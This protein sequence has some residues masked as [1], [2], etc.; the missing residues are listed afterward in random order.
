MTIFIAII[1]AAALAAPGMVVAA[2]SILRY[3]EISSH[4][5]RIAPEY[6]LIGS[7]ASWLLAFAGG[8]AVAGYLP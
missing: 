8:A 5:Q 2:K 6:V 7:L 3:P 4:P 1:V